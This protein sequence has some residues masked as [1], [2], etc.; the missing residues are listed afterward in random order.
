MIIGVH[1]PKLSRQSAHVGPWHYTVL[2]TPTETEI[3]YMLTTEATRQQHAN[4]RTQEP[5]SGGFSFGAA[6]AASLTGSNPEQRYNSAGLFVVTKAP[7]YGH[8]L[9]GFS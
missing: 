4:P 5:V 9:L 1:M 2:C 6:S 7:A 8:V 3:T